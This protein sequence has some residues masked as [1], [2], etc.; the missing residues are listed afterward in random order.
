[1]RRFDRASLD[2]SRVLLKA[3]VPGNRFYSA[4]LEAAHVKPC[5]DDLEQFSTFPFTSKAELVED[6]RL[7]PPF[8]DE[9]DL[10]ARPVTRYHQT[11]GTT[12]TTPL[13]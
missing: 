9:P 5:L 11:S 1:M 6:Q 2:S 13:A 7:H 8:W 10:S 12:G 3:L 4:K